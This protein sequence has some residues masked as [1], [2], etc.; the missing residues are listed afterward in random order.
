LPFY[1]CH[2]P[3]NIL[4][5]HSCCSY[6][7]FDYDS[8]VVLEIR[9]YDVP[10]IDFLSQDWLS[11]A[12]LMFIILVLGEA[13]IRKIAVLGQPRQKVRRPHVKQ[14]NQMGIPAK[15]NCNSSYSRG[16]W[17]EDYHLKPAPG[18]KRKT[19]FEN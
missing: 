12:R 13:E 6:V 2:I 3:Y 9:S 16:S 11:G 4:Q 10:N 17:K 1:V 15:N 8:F 19:L 5:V 14:Q 18:K 7:C